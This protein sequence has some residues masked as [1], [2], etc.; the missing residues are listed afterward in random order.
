ML[1]GVE[2]LLLMSPDADDERIVRNVNDRNNLLLMTTATPDRR[3]CL[4][5]VYIPNNI[6]CLIVIRIARVSTG[7]EREREIIRSKRS[8][9]SIFV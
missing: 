8:T 2:S 7:R 1:L 9:H 6:H 5:C 3:A 4:I